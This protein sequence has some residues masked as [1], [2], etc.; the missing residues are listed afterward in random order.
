MLAMPIT[1]KGICVHLK[2]PISVTVFDEIDSTNTEARRRFLSGVA[3]PALFVANGQTAGRGRQ[4]KSF[5]SPEGC[6]LYLSLLL[7]AECAMGVVPVTT[8]AAVGVSRAIAR[9]AG[10]SCGIKWVNDLYF[11]GKKV[12]GLLAEMLASPDGTRAVVM[13]VGIN[14]WAEAFPEDLPEAGAL[15]DGKASLSA[16]LRNQLAAA[17]TEE[18]LRAIGEK[19]KSIAMAEY[20]AQSTV[21]GKSVF[22]LQNNV[23]YEGIACGITEEGGLCVRLDSGEER[24]LQSGEITLRI[25]K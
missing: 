9:V 7:P 6:G 21:L 2:T 4:G 19:D 25:V 23:R 24:L 11:Q 1:E 8:L 10:I 15:F 14:V 17:V 12:A 20:R 5:Y 18:I 13:G 16:D 22:F 3:A